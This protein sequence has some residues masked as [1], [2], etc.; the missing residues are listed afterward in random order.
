M[1]GVNLYNL[2]EHIS[3]DLRDNVLHINWDQTNPVINSLMIPEKNPYN[4]QDRDKVKYSCLWVQVLKEYIF[5]EQGLIIPLDIKSTY[6]GEF[7]VVIGD[8]TSNDC[9]FTEIG[10]D[11]Y[12]YVRRIS[13]NPNLEY[14][15]LEKCN[16]VYN[17]LV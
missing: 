15:I 4:H 3:Y 11:G 6:D 12:L 17:D 5:Y 14:T 13:N 8:E 16:C 9:N 7:R 1:S 10:E 2:Y